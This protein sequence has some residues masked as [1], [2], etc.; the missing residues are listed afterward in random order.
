MDISPYQLAAD[1]CQ[2]MED[3]GASNEQGI[4][5]ILAALKTSLTDS[6]LDKAESLE[7]IAQAWDALER[8]AQKNFDEPKATQ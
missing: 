5:A 6:G 7:L 2:L 8:E 3:A 1:I 4:T